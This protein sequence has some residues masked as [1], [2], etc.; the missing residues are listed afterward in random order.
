MA[1]KNRSGLGRARPKR[2]LPKKGFFM[3]R[4]KQNSAR[5][6]ALLTTDRGGIGVMSCRVLH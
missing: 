2:P 3:Y 6:A 5:R 4:L 1:Q